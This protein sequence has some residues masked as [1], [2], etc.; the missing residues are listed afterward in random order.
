MRFLETA[1]KLRRN[2]TD[3]EKKIWN[4]LRNRQLA[5]YK[6]YRQFRIGNY[7]VDFVCRDINLV[8]E[9][10]GG[11]HDECKKDIERT[12]Y[13]ES[14]G[15]KVIR[16]WNNE[17]LGNIEGVLQDIEN[18]LKALTPTLS[19]KGEGALP[20]PKSERWKYTNLPRALKG[21]DLKPAALGWSAG[22]VSLLNPHAPGA[23]QYG[24]TQ[25][26]DLNIAQ[27]K[28]IKFLSA[29]ETVFIH[30][31]DGAFLS[32]RLIVHVPAGKI[33][34]LIERHSGEGSYWKNGVVQIVIEPNACLRHYRFLDESAKGVSTIFTHAKIA[35]DARYESFNLIAGDGFVRNQFH[36][37]LQGENGFCGIGG[38]NLLQ[39]TQHAD[40]TITI[41][42]QAPRCNSSQMYKSVLKDRSHCVFQG[43]VHVHQ[44]AQKTDGYQL[45]NALILSPEA[46]MDTKPELEIYADDVK[47]SH[48]ATTGR[49][50]DA[51]LFYMRARGIPEE[52]AQAL[53]IEAFCA[54]ALETVS[55]EAMREEMRE[56]VSSWLKP[57]T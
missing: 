47:C 51:P 53:L 5:G 32:P 10:D 6:F 18:I 49:L 26:W 21:L 37:E 28:D 22:N 15:Y 27:A 24:D 11:Q 33:V 42:H 12:K 36:A 44:I 52:E 7:Y 23:A 2:Q 55:D 38:I 13:L 30:A 29:D 17:V 1:R 41:E 54:S 50:D 45:S 25:L 48:G 40:T 16:Y 8:I 19:L 43:K 14:E 35:R 34:T 31:K 9:I 4:L 56:A 20:T 39:N 3:A 46:E 57:R